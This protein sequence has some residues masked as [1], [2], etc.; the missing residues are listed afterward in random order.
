[1]KESDHYKRICSDYK[2]RGRLFRN[3]VGTA[4]EGKKAMLNNSVVLT[5]LRLVTFGLCVGSSDLVGWTEVEIT[6]EMVGKKVAIFTA[7][8]VKKEK[9]GRVK[10]EQ[11][12]FLKAVEKAG[13]IAEIRKV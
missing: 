3:N 11:R 9:G 4:Y 12:A 13:G 6:P 10:K 1:M 5:E 2:D 7:V 8:E